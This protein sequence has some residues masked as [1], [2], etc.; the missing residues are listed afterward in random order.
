L[1]NVEKDF[2]ILIYPNPAINEIKIQIEFPLFDSVNFTLYDMMGRNVLNSESTL[3][4][5]QFSTENL[6]DGLY[7]LILASNDWSISKKII[8]NN[9]PNF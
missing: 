6:M 3:N 5:F 1:T 8:I 4:I 2:N 7:T 9:E